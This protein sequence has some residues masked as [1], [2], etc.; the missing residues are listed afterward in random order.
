MVN[1][2]N[3]QPDEKVILNL[4][5]TVERR[6]P[7]E[8]ADMIEL[9]CSRLQ[10]RERAVISLHAHNDM[11]M[12]VAASLLAIKAGAER[13]EGTLF[14]H[15]ERTGNVDL[16][17][18]AL[19]LAYAGVETGL[20]FS[21]LPEIVAEIE[22]IAGIPV[23]PR[24]PYAGSLVF[25]AFSGSHQDAIH[26]GFQ[27]Q[28]KIR[29]EFGAY[30][31]PYLHIHPD[32]I[33]RKFENFI[34]INSQSGKGGIAHIMERDFHITMPRWVQIDFA[35]HVQAYADT[36]KRELD[37]EELWE[38]FQKIYK[39]QEGE[40]LLKRYWPRPES[41]DPEVV[42]AEVEGSFRNKEFHLK[43][44][45]NGPI[46][47]FVH[48]LKKIEEL[49]QFSLVDYAEGTRGESADAEGVCFI[50]LESDAPEKKRSIGVGIAQNIDQAAA[51]AIVAAL[52]YLLK[53]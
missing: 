44:K 45:G 31:M 48:A 40:L 12:A 15:G 42:E 41:T 46:S 8:Y 9:F 4:P 53:A 13:V 21:R 38:L 25:T 1:A 34:R 6:F 17:T 29:Q 5:A 32:Y 43:A 16:V 18:L 33:G 7:N 28:D 39:N 51:R 11:G 37:A 52:N 47:A 19:D 23:H 10:N 24:H 27:Q 22:D 36:V 30:K 3:P 2:W 50:A 26:K 14:G 35:R 49:P 20:D